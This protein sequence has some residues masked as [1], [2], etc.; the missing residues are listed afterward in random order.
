MDGRRGLVPS[1]FIEKVP[2]EEL[3]EF[4]NSLGLQHHHDDNL[5][6]NSS[7]ESDKMAD[8]QREWGRREK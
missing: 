6:F 1:N 2:D 8:M 3:E 4:H 7:D 5:D